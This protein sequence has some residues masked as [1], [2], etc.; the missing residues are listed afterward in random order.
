MIVLIG[1]STA[2]DTIDK[3]SART[4]SADLASRLA[5]AKASITS[6][7]ARLTASDWV[8][9]LDNYQTAYRTA[10]KVLTASTPR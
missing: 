5:L 2:V 7:D 9:A 1:K 10:Q 8:G 4:L 6:G 3:A